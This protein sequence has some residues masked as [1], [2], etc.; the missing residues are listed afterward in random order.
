[1]AAARAWVER[2]RRGEARRGL[3]D[4]AINRR[5]NALLE[6]TTTHYSLLATRYSLLT[7]YYSLRTSLSRP[8]S[9]R[10]IAML[11]HAD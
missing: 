1:M 7:T 5:W 10:E 6:R 4:Q 2:D 11:S 8:A 3:G 9:S